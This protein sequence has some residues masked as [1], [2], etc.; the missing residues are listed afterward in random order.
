[1]IPL[2][3]IGID[4]VGFAR[5]K[6]VV[7]GD[8]AW[9]GRQRI[10]RQQLG[11]QRVPAVFGDNVS[12]KGLPR[13][14]G[15]CAHRSLRIEHRTNAGEISI[16]HFRHWHCRS[17]ALAEACAGTFI[18]CEEKC[19]VLPDRS[20]D[21]PAVLILLVRRLGRSDPVGE[22]VRPIQ[23]GVAQKLE[24][25]AVQGVGARLDVHE[26][27]PTHTVSI[28]GRQIVGHHA[29]LAHGVH[30]GLHG[31]GLKSDGPARISQRVVHAIDIHLYLV[32]MLTAGGE[33]AFALRPRS[34]G[35]GGA[36]GPGQLEIVAPVERHFH[37]ALVL[38]H[39]SDHGGLGIQQGR[40]G[41][42]A[43]AFRHRAGLQ[44]KIDPRRLAHVQLDL[45]DF[46]DGKALGGR[47]ERVPANGQ[48]R[49]RVQ[50][51]FIRRG[52]TAQACVEVRHQNLCPDHR[53]FGLIFDNALNGGGLPEQ[54]PGREDKHTKTH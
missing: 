26:H 1:M 38:D 19:L 21:G 17:K 49:Q 13:E 48:S 8:L 11:K 29:E 15:G 4:V 25:R 37:D 52:L 2:D 30:A 27:L 24:Q 7:V 20:P 43:D 40:R 32:A 50:T 46:L 53:A 22:E 14:A 10:E 44:R 35:R 6:K 18:G 5:R 3:V 41:A 42:D 9:I 12:R 28:F 54:L 33:N 34:A 36:G 23:I 51:C 16:A 39:G 47:F 45:R 31:L